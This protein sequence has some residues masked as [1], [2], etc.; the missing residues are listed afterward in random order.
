MITISKARLYDLAAAS[1]L[2]IWYAFAIGGLLI[3]IDAQIAKTTDAAQLALSAG[4]KLASAAFLGLQVVLFLIRRLPVDK[5][6]GW[7]PRVVAVFGTNA[8][9]LFL[10]LPRVELSPAMNLVSSALIIC[11][12]VS[13]VIVASRLGRSFSVLPQAR[14]L[15]TSGPYRLVRH[16][17]YVAEQIATFG[18][19]WQFQQPWALLVALMSFAAQFP[20][21]HYEEKIL[22][23]TFP[24]YRTY[25]E[26][27]AKLI[28]GVY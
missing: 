16:P 27:T 9:I 14:G 3:Q 2:I 11:G 1:P 21:M 13:A 26:R 10:A 28:P 8:A 25:A 24:A 17:L 23:Q 7:W 20:R 22:A 12:S 4:A 6:E 18:I 15:V 19:M 5:A